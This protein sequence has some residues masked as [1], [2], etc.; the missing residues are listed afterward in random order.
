VGLAWGCTLLSK[1]HGVLLPAGFV[2]Y[3]LV[4]PPARRCLRTPGPY[5]ALVVGMALFAPVIGWNAAHDWASFRFQGWRAA[6]G[7]N[8]FKPARLAEAIGEQALYLLP[9]IWLPLVAILIRLVRRGPRRWSEAEAFLACQSVPALGLFMGVAT[10]RHIMPHWPLI[11]YVALMPILGKMWAERLA[12]QPRWQWRWLVATAV[13]PIF[14]AGLVVAQAR[15]ALLLDGRGRLLGMLSP[16]SDPTIELISW[17][18]IARELERRNL[19]DLPA[20]FLFTEDWRDSAQ[21]GFA[22]RLKSPVACYTRDARSFAYW[23]RPEDWVGRD[24]IF[25]TQNDYAHGAEVL[26]NFFDRIEP[27]GDF[28]VVRRGVPIRTVHLFKCVHQTSAFPFGY[29]TEET[30]AASL[31]VPS[32]EEV[33]TAR[34]EKKTAT[35]KR[36]SSKK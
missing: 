5:L 36:S 4:W 9:W 26:A 20:T 12:E 23:S 15:F 8:G 1:Y 19:L 14:L 24:G 25:V 28:S 10:F 27:L 22:T 30:P 11:A 2:L 33:R 34:S 21:L 35:E 31:A 29:T 7:S 32:G 6:V 16:Q 17:D 3:L 13:V 18:P